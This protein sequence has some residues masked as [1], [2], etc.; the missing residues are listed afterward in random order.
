M[1][2]TIYF[3][4]SSL[5]DFI[6]NINYNG[7]I[8]QV[9]IKDVISKASFIKSY[10]VEL[11]DVDSN[12]VDSDDI[13][14]LSDAYK[15]SYHIT[16]F[17]EKKFL[18][19]IP[20]LARFLNNILTDMYEI[21]GIDITMH[22]D[23]YTK[24]DSSKKKHKKIFNDLIK[25]TKIDITNFVKR[26]ILYFFLIIN[27]CDDGYYM[28]KI[29][30]SED[31][32]TRKK[33]LKKEYGT[34]LFLFAIKDINMKRDELH[35]HEMLRSFYPHLVIKKINGVS[36]TEAYYYS[37][38]L[39]EHFN[40]YDG[41]CDKKYEY[42]IEVEKTKQEIEKTKQ[43][44]EVEKTKQVKIK[45]VE[46]TKLE[47]E[48]TRQIKIKETEKTKI[49]QSSM[50]LLEKVIDNTILDEDNKQSIIDKLVENI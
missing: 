6:Y 8:D 37:D 17:S 46:K 44:K 43:T 4:T 40:L 19:S 29:G 28:S 27:M 45:E 16:K 9:I 15:K 47:V 39:L 21:L 49:K 36:T 5:N 24:L 11:S 10:D 34:D 50:S 41:S 30:F 23:M 18:K 42:M 7:K 26:R 3:V 35:F 38:I 14:D 13:K 25:N 1:T 12:E 20:K 32:A 31:I 48:K 22:R 33:D 2:F